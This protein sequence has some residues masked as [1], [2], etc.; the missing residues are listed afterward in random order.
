MWTALLGIGARV[1]KVAFPII[2]SLIGSTVAAEGA[3]GAGNG[4][5]KQAMVEAGVRPVIEAQATSGAIVFPVDEAM[6]YVRQ[7]IAGVVAL[8]NLVGLFTKGKTDG[9]PK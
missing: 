8:F 6:V 3:L 2:M 9:L 7:V 4:L 5:Q 1:G